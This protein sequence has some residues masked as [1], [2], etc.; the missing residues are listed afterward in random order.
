MPFTRYLS[1]HGDFTPATF[2]SNRRRGTTYAQQ[3]TTA[4]L[5][6]SPLL[7]WAERPDKYLNSPAVD[8]IKNMP[9]VWDEI[10]V[11]PQSRIGELVVM[12]K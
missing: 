2:T 6:N 1:G 5:Y 9:Y 8:L 4:M 3:L 11:L 7:I 10:V 12:A